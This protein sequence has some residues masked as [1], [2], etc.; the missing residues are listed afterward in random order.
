MPISQKE[1]VVL[2]KFIGL[3]L[4][5]RHLYKR[6]LQGELDNLKWFENDNHYLSYG[7]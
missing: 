3:E 2:Q 1:K 6:F 4:N 5:V 7:Y